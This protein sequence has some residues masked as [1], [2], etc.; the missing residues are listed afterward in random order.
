MAHM[1]FTVLGRDARPTRY[2]LGDQ[3]VEARLA[4]LALFKLLD[5]PDLPCHVYALCTEEAE[6]ETFPVLQEG[7]EGIAT[8]T[9][10]KVPGIKELSTQEG[11]D[12]FIS[13][14]ARVITESQCKSLSLD[15]THGP[16]HLSFLVYAIALFSSALMGIEIC[17][18]YY[19][20]S[21]DQDGENAFFDLRPLIELPD[22]IHAI[23]V[24]NET[25]SAMAISEILTKSDAKNS[26]KVIRDLQ[27][28]SKA[29]LSGLPLEVGYMA[30]GL[31]GDGVKSLRKIL[32]HYHRL[33]FSDDLVGKL[34]QALAT[35]TLPGNET[36][37][38]KRWVKGKTPLTNDELIRQANYINT[39]IKQNNVTT[40]LGL[41]REWTVSWVIWQQ[42]TKRAQWL[43]HSTVRK[44]AEN[45]LN[46][47]RATAGDKSVSSLLT[48]EQMELANFWKNI[49]DL[50]NAYYH[51]G[52]RKQNLLD[53][54][55][56]ADK[57]DSVL[58]YW[59]HLSS[60]PEIDLNFSR[61][62]ITLVSPIGQK[63]G[64]LFS[65]LQNVTADLGKHPDY[66]IVI[67][68]ESSKEAVPEV[69]QTVGYAGHV[70]YL[71]LDDP[72][73]GYSEMPGLTDRIR[74]PIAESATVL[75]NLTGGTTLMGITAS[76][77]ADK[78]R[79]LN[80]RVRRF[81]L[82]DRRTPEEQD[83]D[84]YR[85]SEILW[86]DKLRTTEGFEDVDEG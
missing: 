69:L 10:T 75:V 3:R 71:V 42:P 27:R 1:L 32:K 80:R 6:K 54:K 74:R 73:A 23:R 21:T 56:T 50:R 35:V 78:A 51:N 84:Q 30:R 20:L 17:G 7:L 68:S 67:C 24:L 55:Q 83:A 41:I 31:L 57:W 2:S 60:C 39:L 43:A 13:E 5:E 28:L 8:V 63:R 9:C 81:A 16:R 25:G 22:W 37:T 58:L 66:C 15:I 52:M 64:V 44:Q 72:H 12:K 40:A 65:A 11:I 19:G 46:S 33:P 34:E 36:G 76:E 48:S 85:V 59:E 38:A 18:A 49:A 45:A 26:K 77:I 61:E 53:D 14:V 47:L 82:I 86:L 79:S 70:I 4:P 29:F 62:R